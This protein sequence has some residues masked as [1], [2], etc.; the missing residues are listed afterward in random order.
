MNTPDYQTVNGS[1]E[2]SFT[3]KKSEFI[4]YIRHVETDDE[5]VAFINDIRA[6]HRKATNSFLQQSIKKN[7]LTKRKTDAIL[8]KV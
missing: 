8:I 7:Y 4:G 2:A 6:M 3:E 1:A 5:A